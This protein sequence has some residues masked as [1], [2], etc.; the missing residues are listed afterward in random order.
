MERNI[1]LDYFKVFLSILV[2]TIHMQPLFDYGELRGWIITH[3]IARIAVP[4]FFITSGYYIAAKLDNVKSLK[5]YLK[6][7]VIIHIVWNLIYLPAIIDVIYN[8][9]SVI[10][11]VVFGF[12]HL[13]YTP[14]LIVGTITL[15][16]SKKYIKDYRYILGLAF[17]LFMIGFYC[18]LDYLK[19]YYYRNGIIMAFP[20]MALGYCIKS[21]DWV[22]KIKNNY[23]IWA[24]C[25]GF[26][27][28][29]GES[30]I[31]YANSSGFNP[32]NDFQLSLLILCPA[33]FIYLQKHPVV[34]SGKGFISI[35]FSGIYF[36]HPL[37]MSIIGM[38]QTYMIYK[39]PLVIILSIVLCY[40]FY[41]I[42][43][44]IKIF[45]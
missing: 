4:I 34:S 38:P 41:L 36:L 19:I 12:F 43:K 35:L 7:L 40:I 33:I 22:K 32:F 18:G 39:L 11:I 14:A 5:K 10:L 26:A 15:F 45:F 13:W 6:H 37:A 29:I 20:L 17:I 2:I 1:R 25:I 28:L 30:Y 31:R 44:R 16:L 23:L 8:I 3:G 27:A 21:R 24:M 42:N 9:K